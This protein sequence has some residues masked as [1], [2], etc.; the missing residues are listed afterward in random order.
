MHWKAQL[1]ISKEVQ[2]ALSI[3]NISNT[4]VFIDILFKK[5]TPSKE[6]HKKMFVKSYPGF[7]RLGIKAGSRINN[8]L[9]WQ[10]QPTVH[11]GGVSRERVTDQQGYRV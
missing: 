8:F 1:N 7:T 10:I 2:Y 3:T 6:E 5:N 11:S 9:S 4:T